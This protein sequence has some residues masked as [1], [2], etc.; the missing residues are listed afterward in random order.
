MNKGYLTTEFYVCLVSTASGVGLALWGI[1]AAEI[2][3]ALSISAAY[4]GG[5]SFVK[6]RQS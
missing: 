4:I 2:L 6:G 3:A 5:R 1:E